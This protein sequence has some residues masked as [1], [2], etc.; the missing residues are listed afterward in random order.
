MT[1][2]PCADIAA[3]ATRAEIGFHQ[4]K[5]FKSFFL[6]SANKKPNPNKIPNIAPDHWHMTAEVDVALSAALIWSSS[7]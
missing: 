6:T 4:G 7:G 3:P 1:L 2:L 5:V